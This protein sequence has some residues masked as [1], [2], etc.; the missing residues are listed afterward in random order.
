VTG[1]ELETLTEST[2]A[3]VVSWF[4]DDEEG[5]RRAGFFR[6]HPKWWELVAADDD[7]PASSLSSR[8]SPWVSSTSNR[9]A[10]A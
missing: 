3:D 7:R 5:R 8:V 2:A 6:L 1:I 9:W 4:E 10:S